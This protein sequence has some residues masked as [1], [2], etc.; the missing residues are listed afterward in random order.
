MWASRGPSECSVP[1]AELGCRAGCEGVV[2]VPRE[3]RP[4]SDRPALR[5]PQGL[6]VMKARFGGQGRH[7]DLG[8][9]FSTLGSWGSRLN[10]GS[11]AEMEGVEPSADSGVPAG[12]GRVTCS[13][14]TPPAPHPELSCTRPTGAGG[15]GQAH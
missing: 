1:Q 4:R 15:P 13:L 5:G 2:S 6:A 3:A 10:P 12:G 14:G 11:S 8:D 7:G 9:S